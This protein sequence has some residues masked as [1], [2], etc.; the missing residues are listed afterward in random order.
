MKYWV[1]KSDFGEEG[2][3]LSSLP[4]AGP[5]D[6]EYSKGVSLVDRHPSGKASAMYYDTT[7]PERTNLNDFVDNLDGVLIANQKVKTILSEFGI[8]NIEYLPVQLMDHQD[9]LVSE[10]YS[11]LNVLGGEDIV[12]ME[13]SEYRMGRI[14]KTQI[15]RIISLA[16]DYK[17]IPED[18]HLFRASMKLDEFFISD[19][20]K[21]AFEKNNITGY[22]VMAADGWDD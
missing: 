18:A 12:D 3:Y 1:F 19:E 14:I 2:V 7:Y 13:V 20:L 17:N 11:I 16:V 6:Y 22:C 15:S 10:D 21:K 9:K 5:K 4:G 8:K